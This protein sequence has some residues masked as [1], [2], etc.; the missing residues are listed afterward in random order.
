MRP[1]PG[2]SPVVLVEQGRFTWC[3]SDR[4]DT[5]EL[6]LSELLDLLGSAG[7]GSA[8]RGTPHAADAGVPG[9]SGT[10]DGDH[11]LVL[12]PGRAVATWVRDGA[13]RTFVDVADR[14][15]AFT[16]DHL[17]VVAAWNGSSSADELARRAGL[18]VERVTE[19]ADDLQLSGLGVLE[20]R[21]RP[22]ASDTATPSTTYLWEPA[23]RRDPGRTG[24]APV[25]RAAGRL[26]VRAARAGVT[27]VGARLAARGRPALAPDHG[28]APAPGTLHEQAPNA[29]PTDGDDR[30]PVY[31]FWATPEGPHMGGAAVVAYARVHED[32]RLNRRYDLRKVVPAEAVVAELATRSGPA[33]LLCSDYLWS[34]E[35]NQEVAR[36]VLAANPATL[37]IHGGPSAPRGRAEAEE[38][39]RRLGPR[40]VVVSGEGE[41]TLAHALAALMD[42]RAPGA[43]LDPARLHGVTGIGFTDPD[44]GEVVVTPA[45]E[46][47]DHLD[48]F[49]S[50]LLSGEFDLVPP[51]VLQRVSVPIE[52]VRG[53]PY[54]CTFCDWGQ[55]TMTRI[56]TFPEDRIRGELDWLADH[57]IDFW[58]VA[59]ANWGMLP[60]DLDVAEYIAELHGRTGYPR[61]V[62][63]GPPKN[64][65]DR[66]VAIVDTLLTAGVSLKAAIALQ[67]RD[68]ATLDA[69]H[70][71]NIRTSTYDRIVEEMRRRNLPLHCELMLG[72][73]GA[74]V[75]SLKADLQWCLEENI[76]PHVYRTFVLPNA[77]MNDPDYQREH[78]VETEGGM[79]VATNT[80][81]RADGE[82]MWRLAYAYQALELLGL[83]RYTLR[84]LQ[85]DLGLRAMD[86]VHRI[87]EAVD[88]K[89]D[90]YP[91]LAFVL[92]HYE[93]FIVPP[94]GWSPFADEVHRLLTAELGVVDTAALRCAI[95]VDRHTNPWPGRATPFRVALDHDATSWFLE[96]NRRTRWTDDGTTRA[97]RPL[98]DHGPGELEVLADP[99]GVADQGLGRQVDPDVPTFP[100]FITAFWEV[101]HLELLSELVVY[102]PMS[103]RFVE[104]SRRLRTHPADTEPAGTDDDAHRAT[105]SSGPPDDF[106]VEPHRDTGDPGQPVSLGRRS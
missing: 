80:Y 92:R 46:R 70:R 42:D 45:R 71:S 90:E 56:R 29:R 13:L 96:N 36:E 73:P 54:G 9:R 76:R 69:V 104:A 48:D 39:L 53:C 100:G 68:Q 25:T 93:Q 58:V 94:V 14:W 41:L 22:A 49:P 65:T 61:F 19:L 18:P 50:A 84:H 75:E 35:A 82:L 60:R 55:A 15:I 34:V 72:L 51:E 12:H 87:V 52:T 1:A 5:V 85:W 30:V 47:H 3:P 32:G 37:V 103:S 31:S 4:N 97:P 86:T 77:P 78:G 6:G 63:A 10:G 8:P 91:L 17:R 89:H 62:G 67:S 102:E 81:T 99:D 88:R 98:A 24:L 21:I 27:R 95:E 74:T 16:P 38:L 64:S 79:V 105:T 7:D 43:P 33:V 2:E 66:Y 59:D 101:C 106:P 20:H 57:Q 44:S 11:E 26:A 28:R 23:P 40:H 83:C